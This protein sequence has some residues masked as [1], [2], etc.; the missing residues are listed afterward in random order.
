[1]SDL[2]PVVDSMQASPSRGPAAKSG[3][4]AINVWLIEDNH[5]FR[6]TIARVL[7]H[8]PGFCCAHDFS[9]SED[10]LETLADGALPDVAL[11]D[12]ELPGMNGIQAVRRMKSMSP[13]TRIIMLTVFDD[14]DK[15]FKAICAG[16]SGY[17]LKTAP[18]EKI[19]ESIRDV[20]A[21][22][23]PMTPRVARSVL[24]MF[25]RLVVPSRDY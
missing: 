17:L 5:S 1:M 23:A 18:V 7:N 2:K 10:A 3:D 6:N 9:N 11:V 19:V 25:S 15:I 16:A 12:V 22:G 20:H 21:G 8:V 24:E 14:H 4:A 13:A